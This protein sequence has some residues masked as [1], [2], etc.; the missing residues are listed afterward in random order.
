MRKLDDL[1]EMIERATGPDRELDFW[2]WWYGASTESKKA[3]PK[4]PPEDYAARGIR[5]ASPPYTASA[6]ASYSLLP[7]KDHPG[8]TFKLKIVQSGFD[9][10]YCWAEFTWPSTES[11]GRGR[12][13]ELAVVA[14]ALRAIRRTQEDRAPKTA[15]LRARKV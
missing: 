6:E 12:T 13:P 3:N 14:C 5:S 1:I 15:A 10:F 2:C 9:D 4:P 11:Q 7:W 8:A